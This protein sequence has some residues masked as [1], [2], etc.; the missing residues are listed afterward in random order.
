MSACRLSGVFL[1]SWVFGRHPAA[2]WPR[3]ETME[4]LSVELV[5]GPLRLIAAKNENS[6]GELNRFLAKS[7]SVGEGRRARVAERR[8]PGKG[9]CFSGSA[10][11][12]SPPARR[13]GPGGVHALQESA[14]LVFLRGCFCPPPHPPDT[15]FSF[16]FPT[17]RMLLRMLFFTLTLWPTDEHP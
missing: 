9:L 7:V 16:P 8:V 6:S 5:S 17:P 14:R 15:C 3:P 1:P 10:S 4:H 2:P 11:I 12:S 13:S